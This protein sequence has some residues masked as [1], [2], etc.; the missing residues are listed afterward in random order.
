[1]IWI[2]LDV[3]RDRLDPKIRVNLEDMEL[4][5][6]FSSLGNEMIITKYDQ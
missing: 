1:M 3:K 2:D 5:T 4:W 6:R